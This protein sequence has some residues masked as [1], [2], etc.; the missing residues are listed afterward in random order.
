MSFTKRF[1]PTKRKRIGY[2]VC[3]LAICLSSIFKLIIYREM[4]LTLREL[5]MLQFMNSITDKPDWHI[6]VRVLVFF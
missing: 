3:P 1:D 2:S 4:P 5:Y 6:K